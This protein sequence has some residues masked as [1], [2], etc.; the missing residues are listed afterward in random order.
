MEAAVKDPEV[1]S[2]GRLAAKPTNKLS[3]L[4]KAKVVLLKK[5]GALPEDG[6]PSA[7]DLQKYKGM[8]SR[9][10]APYFMAAVTALVDAVSP[11]RKK[12]ESPAAALVAAV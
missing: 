11:T 10:L 6:I 12:A 4:D 9:A 8:Y 5:S 3:T 7:K 1:R 2:S